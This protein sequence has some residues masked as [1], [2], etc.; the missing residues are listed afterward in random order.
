MNQRKEN[1]QG[2]AGPQGVYVY[3]ILPGDIEVEGGVPGVGDRPGEIRAVR[4]HDLAALV[5]DVRLDRPLGRPEDLIAH[6]EVLDASAADVPVLPL[7]FGSV[8][9]DDDA[10]T[11][12]LLAPHHDEFAGALQR[13][14]GTAEFVVRGRYVEDAIL[15]DVLA[16][17]RA[18]RLREQIRDADPDATRDLRIALGEIVSSAIEARRDVD[19]RTL[20]QE[21]DGHVAAGVLRPPTHELDAVH[22]AFL[23]E[24]GHAAE[25]RR[26]V[27]RLA[28]DW[29]D[30][31]ELRLLGPLAAYD[32]VGLPDQT[33]ATGG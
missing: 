9:T 19:S 26:T 23:V 4:H 16:D 20:A 7:R 29:Q 31:I 22:G 8:L 11:G 1:G 18:A 25:L 28:G 33:G 30:Q 14:E 2:A 6:Q 13:L 15:R 24:H 17:P 27:E 21:L 5:S 3:G 32:F 10:V 12:E